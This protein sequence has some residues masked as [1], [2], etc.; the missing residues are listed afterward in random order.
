MIF[1]PCF[2]V[3][4]AYPELRLNRIFASDRYQ[5]AFTVTVGQTTR[6]I[7]HHDDLATFNSGQSE[8][9]EVTVLGNINERYPSISQL[10]VS[11]LSREI[12][13]IP[14]RY[15]ILREHGS[16]AAAC[17]AVVDSASTT[18]G[19][20][21]EL[22]FTL[23]PDVNPTELLR[24]HEEINTRADM[25]GSPLKLPTS[26]NL[27][28]GSTLSTS[29][30]S[31]FQY[32]AGPNTPNSIELFIEI[33]DQ[34]GA[35]LAVA[36]VNAF[37]TLLRRIHEPLLTG[38]I[39]LKLDEVFP[40]RIDVP[41]VLSFK[42][43]Q[44]GDNTMEEFS[45]QVDEA[46]ANVVL[47]SSSAFDLFVT[48]VALVGVQNTAIVNF[49]QVVQNGQS[50]G[51]P[52]PA[53]HTNLK[54]FTDCELAIGDD[55]LSIPSFFKFFQF[56]AVDVQ[57]TQYLFAVNAGEVGF[58]VKAIDRIEVDII[59]TSVSTVSIPPLLLL[60]ERTSDSTHAL[61]PI[62]QAV[63]T[64]DSSLLFTVHFLEQ[65]KPPSRFTRQNDFVQHPIFLL[66]DI[67]VI[68]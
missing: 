18:G 63:T 14:S 4:D 36:S 48:R 54:V 46:N 47:T 53:D 41:V 19:S 43:T 38:S 24:L 25:H 51:L 58:Q 1:F 23:V 60:K 27:A 7:F 66:N 57:D 2:A 28:S 55:T 42:A 37:L 50:I 33:K 44:R 21:F 45:L 35:Q 49:N 11:R 68:V 40:T 5:F 34:P 30:V 56:N 67:D 8:F 20:K 16:C 31:S 32:Q 65:N 29:F 64:L 13:I 3:S 12:T 59:L 9:E 10:F 15:V 26:I 22:T 6:L 52:L 62:V 39:R 61:V 17:Q